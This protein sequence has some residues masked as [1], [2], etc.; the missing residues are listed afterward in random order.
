MS[1]EAE[2]DVALRSCDGCG[3]TYALGGIG[4]TR[5]LMLTYCCESCAIAHGMDA[6][7]AARHMQVRVTLDGTPID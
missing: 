4:L 2:Q 5:Q 6:V 3:E 7:E 1:H